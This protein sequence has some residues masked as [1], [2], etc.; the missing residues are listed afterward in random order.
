MKKFSRTVGRLAGFWHNLQLG[1]E[2][3]FLKPLSQDLAGDH[4]DSYRW[5]YKALQL[6]SLEEM[7]SLIASLV[8]DHATNI[9]EGRIQ[10]AD[11]CNQYRQVAT[12][13][14]R[15]CQDGQCASSR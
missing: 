8:R 7:L 6:S 5:M 11:F 12:G 13:A 14:F 2:T 3:D 1:P 15:A 4:A 9:A 10:R